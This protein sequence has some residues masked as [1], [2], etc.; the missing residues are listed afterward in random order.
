MAYHG[1]HLASS[2]LTWVLSGS[3]ALSLAHITKVLSGSSGF[4]VAYHVSPSSLGFSLAHNGSLGFSLAHGLSLAH[5][6]SFG[7]L[8]FFLAHLD[9]S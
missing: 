5:R 2:S 1:M 7:S 3:P 6:G 4:S 9:S 8:G